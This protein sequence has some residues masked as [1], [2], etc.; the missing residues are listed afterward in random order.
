MAENQMVLARHQPVRAFSLKVAQSEMDG[1][2]EMRKD[3]TVALA[4]QKSHPVAPQ[5]LKLTDQ[6]IDSKKYIRRYLE[7]TQSQT[8][9]YKSMINV[10]ESGQQEQNQLDED[11]HNAKLND[12]N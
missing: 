8:I 2:E 11:E 12:F 4:E 5:T 9:Q 10:S 7:F 3:G 1:L 6:S